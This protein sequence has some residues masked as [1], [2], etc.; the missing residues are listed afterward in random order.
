MSNTQ[1]FALLATATVDMHNHISVAFNEEFRPAFSAGAAS[2]GHAL[3]VCVFEPVKHAG[4]ATAH[5]V[6]EHVLQPVA[7]ASVATGKYVAQTARCVRM[8]TH[9]ALGCLPC[10]ALC[11]RT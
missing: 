3:N 4:A 11:V 2:V 10:C 6:H 7:H 1:A 9:V 5:A 8:R